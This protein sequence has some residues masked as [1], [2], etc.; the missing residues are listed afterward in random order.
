MFVLVL[1]SID[2]IVKEEHYEY[3]DKENFLHK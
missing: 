1:F 3:I 2:K